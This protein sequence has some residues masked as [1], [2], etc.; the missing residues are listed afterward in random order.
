MERTRLV[1]CLSLFLSMAG[2]GITVPVMPYLARDLGAGPVEVS[3]LVSLFAL[4]SFLA[5]PVW[6]SLSDH[7]GRRKVLVAGLFGYAVSFFLAGFAR[8]AAALVGAR[9][10]G[11]LLSASVFPAS[12]ALMADLTDRADRGPAMATLG[13]W[14]NLGF[15]LGPVIGGV[16][17]PLGYTPPLFAAGGVVALTGVLA[18]LGLGEGGRRASGGGLR[19][20]GAAASGAWT[21]PADIATAVRSPIGPYLWLTFAITYSVSGLTAL[22][23]YFIDDRFGGGAGETGAVFSAQGLVAFA[24]QGF[25]LGALL[26]RF[27][28]RRLALAGAALATAGFLGLVAAPGFGWAL[29]A[30]LVV[31]LGS[32]LVRPSLTS[33]VSLRTPL[34]QGLSLGVQAS[35]D[36]FGRV[37]G[38]TLGG[39]L[40]SFGPTLPLGGAALVIAAVGAAAAMATRAENLRTSPSADDVV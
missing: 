21:R 6:G 14:T 22:A 19:A 17:A 2:Y 9:V 13:A 36:A 11:G 20:S 38:P 12:Q 31:G 15:L 32:S 39:W 40:Y 25:V 7:F 37:A 24:V 34:P 27:G 8:S 3:F 16:M 23:A 33:A 5:S 4:A 26:R 28:E 30:A 29:A 10:L 18:A 1:V 35:F